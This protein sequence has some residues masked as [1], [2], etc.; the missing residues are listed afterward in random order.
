MEPA[1]HQIDPLVYDGET[2]E[3][4]VTNEKSM[5]R[6]QSYPTIHKG[7]DKQSFEKL[8]TDENVDDNNYGVDP[9][10]IEIQL[11]NA[12]HNEI[13]KQ[14]EHNSP[15]KRDRESEHSSN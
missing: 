12:L 14:E 3:S 13:R 11:E 5:N 9:S 15:N 2:K 10:E 6:S 8:E 1:P 4:P 7:I